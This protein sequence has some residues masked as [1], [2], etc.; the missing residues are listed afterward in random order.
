MTLLCPA[1][2][3][4][5]ISFS[6]VTYMLQVRVKTIAGFDCVDG[7]WQV[8]RSIFPSWPMPISLHFRISMTLQK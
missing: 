4:W 7:Y 5:F 1:N 2:G 3:F 6:S 8:A